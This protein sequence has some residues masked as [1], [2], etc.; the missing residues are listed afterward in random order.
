MTAW[1]VCLLYNLQST[2]YISAISSKFPP[3][4]P[5]N[6]IVYH[7]WHPSAY[8]ILRIWKS[9]GVAHRST[10]THDAIGSNLHSQLSIAQR[11]FTID[12]I[13]DRHAYDVIIVLADIW[14]KY[15]FLFLLS[16]AGKYFILG[17]CSLPH[18]IVPL[19]IILGWFVS[20]GFR[21]RNKWTGRYQ[22][23]ESR[24]QFIKQ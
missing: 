6:C 10:A 14:I 1:Q 8:P 3:D 23:Y 16:T 11:D 18:G 22:L 13:H 5:P 21:F 17:L 20:E 19:Y 12:V 2:L 4:P 7:I 9:C 15:R 24:L